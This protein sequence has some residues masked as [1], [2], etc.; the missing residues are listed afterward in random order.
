[1]KTGARKKLRALFRLIDVD[2]TVGCGANAAAIA[3][4][5]EL[6]IEFNP[7]RL[8]K[9]WPLAGASKSLAPRHPRLYPLLYN[10][11]RSQRAI[12]VISRA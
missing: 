5:M 12:D 11:L 10:A 1:M 4:L 6:A 3:S 7:S 9:P 8:G 2:V